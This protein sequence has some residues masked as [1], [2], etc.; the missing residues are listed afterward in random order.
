MLCYYIA[1][2]CV[3]EVAAQHNNA[4]SVIHFGRS[5]LSPTQ[6]LPVL[7]IF[8][9]QPLDVTHCCQA[10]QQLVPNPQQHILLIYD[11]VYYYCKGTYPIHKVACSF[12]IVFHY[13]RCRYPNSQQ[14]ILPIYDKVCHYCKGTYPNHNNL[15]CPFMI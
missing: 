3:D 7:Y 6:R 13:C 9:Q 2:C 4:D 14:P 5:C 10:L 12:G 11:E 8:G 15:S 1:S